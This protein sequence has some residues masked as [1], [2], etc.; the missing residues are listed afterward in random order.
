[1]YDAAFV[2]IAIGLVP[3]SYT[4]MVPHYTDKHERW[5]IVLSH[6]SN[7]KW[8]RSMFALS[9][10]QLDMIVFLREMKRGDFRR[11]NDKRED[12]L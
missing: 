12:L 10:S 11:L 3:D 9:L 8:Q 2:R 5:Q 1:M 4:L 7:Y 6:V